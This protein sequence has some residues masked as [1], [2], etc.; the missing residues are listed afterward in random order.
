[1]NYDYE[2]MIRMVMMI[3]PAKYEEMLVLDWDQREWVLDL[4]EQVETWL[5]IINIK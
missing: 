5:I 1:M 4:Q 3:T 2:M